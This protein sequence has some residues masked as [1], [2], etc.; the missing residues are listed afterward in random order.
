MGHF[1]ILDLHSELGSVLNKGVGGKCV[2]TCH[3]NNLNREN[4][5]ELLK[6]EGMVVVY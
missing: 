6:R 2:R 4:V 5:V 1:K 3:D